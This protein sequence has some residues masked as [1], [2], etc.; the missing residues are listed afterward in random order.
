ME[1]EREE[2][3]IEENYKYDS[4]P[5]PVSLIVKLSTN[6]ELFGC[7]TFP[8]TSGSVTSFPGPSSIYKQAPTNWVGPGN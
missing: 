6:V 5:L 4:K 7:K 3:E 2:R 8:H 1:E